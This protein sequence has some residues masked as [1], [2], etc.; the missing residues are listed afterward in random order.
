MPIQIVRVRIGRR[1]P[2]RVAG[3]DLGLRQRALG[4][5]QRGQDLRGDKIV[6]IEPHDAR[7]QGLRRRRRVLG[8]ADLIQQPQRVQ[9]AGKPFQKLDQDPR[10]FNAVAGAQR[11]DRAV[12]FE[13]CRPRFRRRPVRRAT[14]IAA[15]PA[16]AGA[17]RRRGGGDLGEDRHRG[18]VYC[19]V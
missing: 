13:D 8:A 16:A 1:K 2:H 5:Q 18:D 17:R 12:E 3:V 7:E 9:M 14:A 6:G 11:G 10:G 19:M 15:Q 4:E